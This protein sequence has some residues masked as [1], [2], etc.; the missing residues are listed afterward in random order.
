M[1]Y[2]VLPYN[3]VISLFRR[4]G[5]VYAG[6]FPNSDFP[7]TEGFIL[8]NYIISTVFKFIRLVHS[9]SFYDIN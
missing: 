5:D 6:K 1:Q 4:F 9:Q 3:L 2:A 8:A 7:Y